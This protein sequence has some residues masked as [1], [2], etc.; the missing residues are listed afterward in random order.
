M[1]PQQRLALEVVYECLQNSGTTEWKGKKIG[2]FFGSYGEVCRSH[3]PALYRTNVVLGLGQ[4]AVEREPRDWYISHYRHRR[5]RTGQSYS[6]RVWLAR[7]IVSIHV[8]WEITDGT[9]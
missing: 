5:L 8:H 4:H 3:G 1:D 7:S 9:H 6:L 2:S